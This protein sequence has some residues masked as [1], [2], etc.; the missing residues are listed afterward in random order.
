MRMVRTLYR[1]KAEQLTSGRKVH[2]CDDNFLRDA[3][4]L[5]CSEIAAV[6]GITSEE[7]K[8]MLREKLKND[9]V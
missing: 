3:E 9:S 1:H 7:A 6:S 4:K 8:L 2:I 5:L